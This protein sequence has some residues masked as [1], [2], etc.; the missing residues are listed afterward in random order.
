MMNEKKKS[1]NTEN[2]YLALRYSKVAFLKN[3]ILVKTS[4]TRR[5]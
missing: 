2:K 3:V 1:E 5:N 4:R